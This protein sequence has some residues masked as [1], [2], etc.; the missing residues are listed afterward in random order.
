M[1]LTQEE[2]SVKGDSPPTTA[3]LQTDGSAGSPA[4]M[5]SECYVNQT[6][7]NDDGTGAV[8]EHKPR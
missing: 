4:K 1:Q 2:Q 5:C 8:N 7:V 6:F 3:A